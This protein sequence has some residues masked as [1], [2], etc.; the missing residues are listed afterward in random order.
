MKAL[1]VDTFNGEGYSGPTIKVS[2]VRNSVEALDIIDDMR[3]SYGDDFIEKE[4][5]GDNKGDVIL[6]LDDG[7]DQGSIHIMDLPTSEFYIIQVRPQ[8]NEVKFFV[9]MPTM[10]K[11]L[12]V[13]KE[14]VV[15]DD[16]YGFDEDDIEDYD[17]EA[18]FG[19]H[20]DNLDCEYYHFEIVQ[21]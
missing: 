15:Y 8:I 2:N 17:G 13:L 6:T 14:Y 4:I 3:L 11:A 5:D 16:K 10:K 12:E 9:K 19:S 21:G 7:E 1:I 18:N 20:A